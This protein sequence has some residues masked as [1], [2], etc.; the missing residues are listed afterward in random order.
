MPKATNEEIAKTV[1]DCIHADEGAGILQ[2]SSRALWDKLRR[3]LAGTTKAERLGLWDSTLEAK[4][5]E[6]Y[7]ARPNAAI[8]PEWDR[9]DHRPNWKRWKAKTKHRFVNI[10]SAT[11]KAAEYTR[12]WRDDHPKKRAETLEHD[13]A[14]DPRVIPIRALTSRGEIDAEGIEDGLANLLTRFGPDAIDPIWIR[15]KQRA[16]PKKRGQ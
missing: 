9:R 8:T 3:Q 10:F 11:A 2:Q 14:S 13:V 12:Q 16:K 1:L 7:Q 5:A 15:A 4:I 6:A